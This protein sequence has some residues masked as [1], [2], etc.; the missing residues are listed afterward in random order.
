MARILTLEPT[1]VKTRKTSPWRLFVPAYLSDTGKKRELFFQT[2]REAKTAASAYKART[3]NFGRSLN[4][5]SP[6]RMAEAAEVYSQ[7]DAQFPDL[8]LTEVFRSFAE[9]ERERTRSVRFATLFDEY[10][11]L[12]KK[13]TERYRKGFEHL[14]ERYRYLEAEFVCDVKGEQLARVLNKL[15]N[16]SRN[17]DM[18]MLRALFN[19]AIRRHWLAAGRNP[20]STLDFA[21]VD[22]R[23]VEIFSSERVSK[24]LNGALERDLEF[25]PW[26]VFGFFC[27]I[28]PDGELSKLEWR[29]VHFEDEKTPQ[30]I[31]RPEVSKTH[32][33]RFVDISPN[34]IAWIR[35][36]IARGGSSEGKVVR[37]RRAN[38][39]AHRNRLLRALELEGTWI[40]QGMRHSYCSYW[41]AKHKDVNTLVLQ[42][43]H[44][45]PDTMWENYHR[46]TTLADAEAFW[47]IAPPAELAEEQQKIV[48][49]RRAK[50]S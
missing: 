5:L 49:F 26:L 3:E 37:W 29:D 50:K 28:R 22:R 42:S 33:R 23:E 25:L 19:L 17:A 44:D 9:R 40:Q 24:L 31:I 18:R 21:S 34:A 14:R 16:G 36:Y 20:V 12:P 10:L 45:D 1:H 2:H 32:R 35:A 47:G 43:G 27:G 30:I 41:L 15:P 4:Q 7:I 48:P 11:L 38:V 39:R 8:T 6:A 13:R 46:G